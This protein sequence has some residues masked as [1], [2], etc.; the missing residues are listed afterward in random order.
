MRLRGSYWTRA[1]HLLALT[2]ARDL[3][4]QQWLSSLEGRDLRTQS[5]KKSMR[6]GKL[7][8]ASLAMSHE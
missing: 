1:T 4:Y 8:W 6:G 5:T 7:I 2:T 3:A